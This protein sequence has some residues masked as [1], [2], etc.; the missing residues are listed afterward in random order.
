[1]PSAEAILPAYRLGARVDPFGA[2][3]V[4]EGRPVIHTLAPRD[5]ADFDFRADMLAA[6]PYAKIRPAF[7]W[8]RGDPAM[9]ATPF[10]P[11]AVL[12]SPADLGTLLRERC[13]KL[14]LEQARLIEPGSVW[15]YDD[16]GEDLGVRWRSPSFDDAA[17]PSGPA[18]LGFGDPIASAKTTVSFGPDPKAKH[19]CTYFRRTFTVADAARIRNLFVELIRDD[20]CVVYVNGEEVARSNMRGGDIGYTTF[21][22]SAVADAAETAWQILAVDPR[23]VREGENVI[24]VEVHQSDATSS[25]LGFDLGLVGYRGP[26]GGKEGR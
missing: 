12:V 25:D 5:M 15:K 1:V 7:A 18:K 3:Y 23:H 13:E 10:S 20:G 26:A 6:G 17:W 8:A 22:T 24:A 9:L 14:P 21:A 11:E 2:M 16:R 19:P 4:L